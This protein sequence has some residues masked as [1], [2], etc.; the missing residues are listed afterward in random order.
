[1]QKSLILFAIMTVCVACGP[2]IAEFENLK[3]ENA[4]LQSEIDSLNQELDAYK[5][6]PEKLFADAQSAANNEDK[7]TLA[8]ILEQIHKYHPQASEC[9]K[10]Q[11]LL[12]GVIAKENAQKEAARLKAEK[13][14]QERLKAVNKLKKKNDDVQ[15]ITWYYNPYFTHY[16]N[17]NLVS[18]Y[19]GNN[20]SSVW[21]R[22]M[23]S[24]T[25]DDWIFFEHAY[26]SY[27]GITRE[28][29]FNEYQDKKSDNS[30]GSV[31][32]WIDLGVSNDDLVFLKEMVN[33]KSVKMQ[34]RGKYTKTRKVS[35]NEIKAIKEMIMAY[36]V[37][38]AERQ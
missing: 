4:K 26:L 1:M 16:T 24:Y 28:F 27:D 14:K 22:L 36:E 30:G 15:G 3:N 11:R 25:G 5:H 2:S 19:M 29:P 37:L 12:D 10:V 33:G 38:Q 18:L 31:W 8:K 9:D 17:T 13:E 34:L 23:M 21:L 6:S 20:E 7:E 32:E 35:T